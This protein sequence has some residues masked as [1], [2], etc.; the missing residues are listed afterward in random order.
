MAT[1]IGDLQVTGYAWPA[2]ARRVL[3]MARQRL[4]GPR[5]HADSLHGITE[6]T[7]EA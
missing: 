1:S 5:M 7:Q 3:V 6:I 4:A 2:L